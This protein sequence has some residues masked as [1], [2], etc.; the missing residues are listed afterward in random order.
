[1]AANATMQDVINALAALTTSLQTVTVNVQ[2]LT[3]HRSTPRPVRIVERP[4]AFEGKDSETSRLFR[5]AFLM[6]AFDN[7]DT[8]AERDAQG[9][10]QYALDRTTVLLNGSSLIRSALSYMKGDAAV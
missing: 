2:T 1:M 6:W 8:F 7:S 4:T 5:S 9:N 3:N 10:K